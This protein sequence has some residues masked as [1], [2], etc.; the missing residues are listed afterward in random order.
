MFDSRNGNKKMRLKQNG[1]TGAPGLSI[2]APNKQV[3]SAEKRALLDGSRDRRL[4][5]PSL[6]HSVTFIN[7]DKRVT[8]TY[9]LVWAI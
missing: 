5:I 4:V 1:F 6:V 8:F 7:T 9:V 2:Y 3:P